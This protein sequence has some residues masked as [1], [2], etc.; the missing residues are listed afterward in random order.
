LQASKVQTSFAP[1][2]RA[3]RNQEPPAF[4]KLR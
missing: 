2:F 1:E 3:T 4:G